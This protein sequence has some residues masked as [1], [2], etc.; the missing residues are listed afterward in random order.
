MYKN[1]PYSNFSPH[2]VGWVVVEFNQ[3]ELIDPYSDTGVL[4][5]VLKI[6]QGPIFL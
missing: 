6:C 5:M 1:H 2:K 4:M 3:G